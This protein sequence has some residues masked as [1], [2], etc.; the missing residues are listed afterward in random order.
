MGD[1]TGTRAGN[2][3]EAMNWRR[4]FPKLPWEMRTIYWI[5]ALTLIGLLTVIYFARRQP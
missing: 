3:E 5:G 4:L 2:A 1:R